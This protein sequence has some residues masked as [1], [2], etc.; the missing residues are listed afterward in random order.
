MA[1]SVSDSVKPMRVD[2]TKAGGSDQRTDAAGSGSCDL[3]QPLIEL[4][5]PLIVPQSLFERMVAAGIDTTG[6]RVNEMLPTGE[7]GAADVGKD[8]STR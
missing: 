2:A 7:Q 8:C 5:P 1:V 4:W 6:V 3:Q